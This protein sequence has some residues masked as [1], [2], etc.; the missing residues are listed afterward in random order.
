VAL[1]RH[2]RYDIIAL[3]P[4]DQRPTYDEQMAMLRKAP[5]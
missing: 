3:A 5:G 4:T 1:N 2:E